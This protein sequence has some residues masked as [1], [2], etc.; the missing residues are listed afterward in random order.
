MVHGAHMFVLSIDVQAGLEL[1]VAAVAAVRN[2]AQIF[3]VQHDMGRL[4]TG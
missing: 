1:A 2:G 4:S 3:L